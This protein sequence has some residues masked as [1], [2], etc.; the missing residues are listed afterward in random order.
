MG[1]KKL[2]RLGIIA[3]TM[4]GGLSLGVVPAHAAV[5]FTLAPTSGPVGSSIHVTGAGCPLG[6]QPENISF[7]VDNGPGRS[8]LYPSAPDGSFAFDYTVPEARAGEQSE[9]SSYPTTLLCLSTN[10]Q[11]G[12]ANFTITGPT[13]TATPTAAVAGSTV[14]VTGQG[15]VQDGDGANDARVA[16]D[17]QQITTFKAQDN[18]SFSFGFTVPDASAG[19]HTLSV[20]CLIQQLASPS[21]A[22]G[23][24]R[25]TTIGFAI[26]GNATTATTQAARRPTRAA[27]DDE[28]PGPPSQALTDAAA[29]AAHASGR[30]PI[31]VALRAPNDI[32][33]RLET[34]L[35]NVLLAILLALLVFPAVLFNSTYEDNYDEVNGWF[36]RGPVKKPKQ[37]AGPT[38]R[39][40]AFVAVVLATAALASFLDPKLKPDRATVLLTVGVASAT[41]ITTLLGHAVKRAYLR[42]TKGRITS[43]PGGVLMA[44]VT[45]GVSRVV[46]FLPGYLYGI[47][48]GFESE[49]QP[50]KARAGRAAAVGETWSVVFAVA[51]WFGWQ[52]VAERAMKP[53]ASAGIALADAVLASIAAL[54]FQGLLFSMIPIKSLPGETLWKWNR[55]AWAGF[56]TVGA[57]SFLHVIAH[58]TSKFTGSLIVMYVLFAVF[59]AFSLAFWGYFRFRKPK[60]P[61][62]P[63]MPAIPATPASTLVKGRPRRDRPLRAPGRE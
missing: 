29:R 39:W 9:D 28:K 51:C 2:V 63:T 25:T 3:G 54:S 21:G 45:V 40:A 13:V 35:L 12:G 30:S 32:S 14:G 1:R 19:A 17:G 24:R 55:A 23:Q 26:S 11:L 16:F 56:F 5:S 53:H 36:R 47:I 50:G 34:L 8:A 4:L 38:K 37:R 33:S 20:D 58:P 43:Y 10:E 49:P 46:H 27:S 22:G 57:F 52:P 48:G 18:A 44:A 15:C 62:K 61:K 41:A 31:A 6:P 42:N 7:S 59:G 60:R